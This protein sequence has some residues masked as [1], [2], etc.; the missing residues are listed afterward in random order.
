MKSTNYSDKEIIDALLLN[1]K[2]VLSFLYDYNFETLNQKVISQ[3]GTKQDTEDV[4]HDALVVLFLKIKNNNLELTSSVH[5]FLQGIARNFWKRKL[6]ENI[7]KFA[8][9]EDKADEVLEDTADEEFLEVERR[10][11]YLKHLADM[12]NDCKRL[13]KMILEGLSLQKITELIPYNSVK[14]TK[15]KRTRCKAKLIKRIYNDPLFNKLKDE[16]FRTT[17]SIPRW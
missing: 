6:D 14:F 7:N 8:K 17:D 1:D 2:Q 16:K 12:P 4:F 11:L 3:G 15:T 9:A 5:T 13:I 10:K